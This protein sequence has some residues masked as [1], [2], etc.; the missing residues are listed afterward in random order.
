MPKSSKK[1]KK[2]VQK[3]PKKQKHKKIQ[4]DPEMSKRQ[5]QPFFSC[6]HFV[7]NRPQVHREPRVISSNLDISF[8]KCS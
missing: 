1:F 3:V 4:K 5:V 7:Q 8:R 6:L 2:N